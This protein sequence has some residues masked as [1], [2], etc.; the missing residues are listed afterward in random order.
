[1][2]VVATKPKHDKV[3]VL[4]APSPSDERFIE[5]VYAETECRFVDVARSDKWHGYVDDE[6]LLKSGKVVIQYKGD[7]PP[8]AGNAVFVKGVDSQGWDVLFTLEEAQ[9]L[10]QEIADTAQIVGVTKCEK[11]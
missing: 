10:T 7:Y 2:Y 8:L 11:Y 9:T 4:Q 3:G 1:M 6:G 5:F